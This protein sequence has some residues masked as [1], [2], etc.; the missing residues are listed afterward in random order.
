MATWEYGKLHHEGARPQGLRKAAS[1]AR[2]AALASLVLVLL[3]TAPYWTARIPVR[4]GRVATPPRITESKPG[5]FTRATPKQAARIAGTQ[6]VAPQLGQPTRRRALASSFVVSFGSFPHQR[7][8][9][10]RARVIRSKGYHASVTQV[11]RSFHVF[12]RTYR[13]RS[14]AEFWSKI[15]GEIGLR[16][17]VLPLGTQTLTHATETAAFTL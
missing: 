13:D 10:V 15:F 7:T 8:A 12:S 14:R 2:L 17:R 5:A 11:G 4:T 16:T 3:S 6:T 1:L 9:E